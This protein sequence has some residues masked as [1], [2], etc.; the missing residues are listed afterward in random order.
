MN[1]TASWMFSSQITTYLLKW[2]GIQKLTFYSHIP[3][4][5]LPMGPNCLSRNSAM[6]ICGGLHWRPLRRS[7]ASQEILLWISMDDLIG[8]SW[9]GQLPLK[10][11]CYGYLLTSL[12][13]N[14]VCFSKSPTLCMPGLLGPKH[15]QHVTRRYHFCE[16]LSMLS[17]DLSLLGVSMVQD[18]WLVPIRQSMLESWQHQTMGYHKS[19]GACFWWQYSWTR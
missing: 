3:F 15:V 1:L 12:V 19:D 7:I 9:D 4:F 5:P 11:F 6:D 14:L 18:L 13:Q 17:W 2:P 16:Q 10:K 8:D